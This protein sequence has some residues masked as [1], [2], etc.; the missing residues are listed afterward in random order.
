MAVGLLLLPVLLVTIDNTVLNFALPAIAADLQPSASQQLWLIDVYP[1]V[2]CSLLVAGGNLGDRL[3]RRRTLLFG[4]AGFTVAS[5]AAAFAPTIELLLA[6]RIATGVFGAVILPATHSLV[7]SMF[8]DRRQR[9]LAIAV[10]TTGFASGAA[11]GPVVGGWLVGAFGWPAIFLIAVPLVLPLL[12]GA[13]L[14]DEFRD[15]EPGPVDLGSIVL[16]A[17]TLAPIVY[18][19][20]HTA[21]HGI[22]SIALGCLV[23]GLASGVLFVRRLL[24]RPNPMLDVRLFRNP[25]FTGSILANLISLTGVTGFLYFAAQHLQVVA[26]LSAFEAAGALVPGALANIVAGLVVVR[27]VR[28]VR[29]G[30][31]VTAGLALSAVAYALTA[32]TT[33]SATVATIAAAYLLIGIGVGMIGTTSNDIMLAAVP[34]KKAGAAAA[35][36]ETAYELGAVLGVTVLG[37]TLTAIYRSGLELP[38]GLT[39]QQAA[40]AR[41]TLAGAAEVAKGLPEPVATQVASQVASA[42]AAAFDAG[43]ATTSVIATALLVVATGVIFALLRKQTA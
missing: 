40:A 36:S 43:A 20:K 32:A 8:D 24:Y 18:A 28:Y 39:D 42:A 38:A 26:G 41:E 27:L 1:L 9:R 25:G 29:P 17:L 31:A 4:A 2:L 5:V 7:R 11:L 22:D 15:P 23:L 35:V 34:P 33:G 21:G 10:L 37:G 6:A 14:I 12:V 30:T 16:S 13:R 3:G 19:I